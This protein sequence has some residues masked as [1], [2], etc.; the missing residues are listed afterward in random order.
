[1]KQTL[2]S[3]ELSHILLKHQSPLLATIPEIVYR[4]IDYTSIPAERGRSCTGIET[5][6]LTHSAVAFPSSAQTTQEDNEKRLSNLVKF[7]HRPS[8]PARYAP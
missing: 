5:Q 2:L 6:A 3:Q 4:I 8:R 1:M 7:P